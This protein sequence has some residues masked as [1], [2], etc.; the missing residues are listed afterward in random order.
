MSSSGFLHRYFLNNGGR[1]LHKWIHY[2]DIYEKHFERFRGASPTV[3]EI[4]IYQGGSLTMWKEYFGAG[5]RIVGVDIDPACKAHEADGIDV[6]IGSQDDPAVIDRIL[7][8]Y[9]PVDIVIDDGS[10]MMKHMIATMNLLYPKISPTGVY[11][12]EDVHTCYWDEYGGAPKK[13][14][15]FIETCKALVDDLN[16]LHTR[17]GIAVSEFTRST[18]SISFYDSIVVLERRPQGARQ[19]CITAG[20]DRVEISADRVRLL[21]DLEAANRA[22]QVE[23]EQRLGLER[24]HE[25]FKASAAAQVEAAM[26]QYRTLFDQQTA[27]QN[28]MAE[29]LRQRGEPGAPPQADPSS[30]I[31]FQCNIC[32]SHEVAPAEAFGRELASCGACGSTV[33]MRSIVHLVSLALWGRSIPL[34]EFPVDK[35][36][37]GK[38]LSC[39][40][41]YADRLREKV[42]YT[43]TFYDEEPRLDITRIPEDMR[44]SC[45][46]LISTDVFE[47]VMPPVQRAFDGAFEILKPG[48]WLIM[49]VPFEL[50]EATVEHYPDVTDIAI[51]EL[52][53]EHL[54]VGRTADGDCRLHRN[55]VFH[56]GPGHTLEMRV[57]CRRDLEKH[58]A[59]AGFTN[60]A[61]LEESVPGPG[62]VLTENWSLPLVARKP[63]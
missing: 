21:D 56:G 60:I 2:F 45:D 7:A 4:G 50:G 1:T 38:G 34:P 27:L 19:T 40:P 58:L 20:M 24:V 18:Q 49:S 63:L 44:A 53:G 23:R 14:G 43:N 22:A 12:V 54:V 55:P 28:E 42:S 17:G 6:I 9:G 16:A 62:I 8:T 57:F 13:E 59:A 26:T 30:T 10:H 37:V 33:R 41:L 52:G 48:G 51:L 36:I 11:L 29:L 31:P 5:C 46:F 3:V 39:W 25:E 61:F 47:H 35:S 32:G 15:T